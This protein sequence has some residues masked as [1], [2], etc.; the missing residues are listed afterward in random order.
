MSDLDGRAVANA[1]GDDDGTGDRQQRATCGDGNR[2][3]LS[4][5]DEEPPPSD[6]PRLLLGAKEAAGLVGVSPSYFYYLDTTGQVPRPVP[7][8][9]VKR[10][11]RSILKRWADAGCPKRDEWEDERR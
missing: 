7:F 6:E 11:V 8:G 2:R 5:R 1:D 10:W 3:A 4:P 9:K